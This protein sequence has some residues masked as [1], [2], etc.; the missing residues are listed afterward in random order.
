MAE[1][2]QFWKVALYKPDKLALD[3]AERR[4]VCAALAERVPKP[5]K[6]EVQA[7]DRR[8]HR[9]GSWRGT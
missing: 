7:D 4:K 1:R 8:W 9:C 2:N 6:R 5:T 3:P